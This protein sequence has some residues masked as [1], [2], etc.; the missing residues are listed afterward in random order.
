MLHHAPLLVTI[1]AALVAAFVLG[2][3]AQKLRL[4]PIVGYL[5]AGLIIGPFTPGYVADVDIASQLAEI[6]VIL[7]M[8]GVG[9]HFSIK[10]LLA[11]KRVAVPGA[12]A[13]M[14]VASILGTGL[15]LLLGWSLGS[16]LLFG[17]AL[18][19]ASTVVLLRRLRTGSSSTPVA[20]T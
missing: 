7:L 4:S 8:F 16:S 18:S 20:A 12:V 19:V 15:G 2:F 17:L 5:V 11:V 13:Q 9:L 3:A 6:G 1:A 14:L 10:D